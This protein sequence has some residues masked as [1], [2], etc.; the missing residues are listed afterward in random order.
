MGGRFITHRGGRF[1]IR[2]MDK[3][4]PVTSPFEDFQ[5]HDET[6]R[7]QYHPDFELHSLF[8]MDRGQEQQSMG[9]VQEYGKGRVFNTTLGHDGNAWKSETFQAIVRRGL[10]W[11]AGRD[12]K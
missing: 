1:T 9:W 10:Y 3:K 4:H 11:A 8:R 2:I 6:Y 5:I 12:P 7:N